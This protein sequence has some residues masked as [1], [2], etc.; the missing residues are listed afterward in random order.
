MW[1]C[2]DSHLVEVSKPMLL[3][4]IGISCISKLLT[5]AL[6]WVSFSPLFVPPSLMSFSWILLAVISFLCAIP[7]LMQIEA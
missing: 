7:S 1:V 4:P 5:L 3:V 6:G 2:Y